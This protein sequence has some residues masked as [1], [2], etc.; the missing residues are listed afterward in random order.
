MKLRW[1]ADKNQ[2]LLAERGIS[3]EVIE[4]VLA[5]AGYLEFFDHPTRANQKM[6]VV[7]VGDYVYA[8]PCVLEANGDLFL[9]T[10]FPS[11]KYKKRFEHG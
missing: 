7:P 6:L 8:V 10:A 2:K 3:F 5:T 1:D 11:R 4:Q 9:K